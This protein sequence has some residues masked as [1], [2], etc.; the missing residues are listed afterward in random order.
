MHIKN[1]HI[2]NIQQHMMLPPMHSNCKKVMIQYFDIA[3]FFLLPVISE[4]IGDPIVCYSL[5]HNIRRSLIIF[6]NSLRTA[7]EIAGK[8]KNSAFLP[9][10]DNHI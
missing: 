2:L 8:K 7:R 3:C 10:L 1:Y 6:G 4:R 5:S 9:N